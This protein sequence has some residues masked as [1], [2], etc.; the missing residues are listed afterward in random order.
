M[1]AGKKRKLYV[2]PLSNSVIGI[3]AYMIY[4]GL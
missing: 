2:A 1:E 3:Q 4:I